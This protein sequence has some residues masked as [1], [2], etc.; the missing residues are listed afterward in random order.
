MTWTIPH[1]R[2]VC[3]PEYEAA[4][5][6]V[7]R[8]GF[9]GQGPEVEAFERELAERFRPH[10]AAAC[11]SSGTAALALALKVL[12][13]DDVAIPTYSCVALAQACEWA[14]LGWLP[15]DEGEPASVVVHTYGRPYLRA[16]ECMVEDFTHAPGAWM[17]GR[18]CGSFGTCS[19]ISFGATK[20]LG[21]GSGG[22][23]LG[24]EDFIAEVRNLRDYDLPGAGW[25]QRTN[26]QWHD[27]GAAIGRARLL[28]LD[29]DN[30]SRRE[31]SHCYVA[32]L[33]DRVDRTHDVIGE[34]ACEERVWYRFVVQSWQP[35]E[36]R[37]HLASRGI[38]A[39]VPLRTD[40]LLHRR[41]SMPAALYPRA[42]IL[43]KTTLSLPIW[44]G[45]TDEQVSLVCD[46]IASTPEAA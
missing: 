46:A 22:A 13:P 25:R 33:G 20:P 35:E 31:T 10:G 27:I 38:E 3:R 19:V 5:L 21:C 24:D 16:R 7:M 23:V 44:P 37:R 32:R 12:K 2:W 45:M 40:E 18:R 15:F 43:A 26:L 4:A 9:V 36:M 28:T 30:A 41:R 6:R 42:E 39:I 14:G 1:N 11:V 8:S 34:G 17:D 29:A